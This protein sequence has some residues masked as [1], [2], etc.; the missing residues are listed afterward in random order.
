MNL[1]Q[2][3]EKRN[4][5]MTDMSAIVEG[6]FTAEKRTQFDTM[7]QEI[8]VLDGDI[9]RVKAVEE[10]RA[11]MKN[12]VNQPRPNPSESNDPEERAE[13]RAARQKEAL[14]SYM[15]T[16][17]VESRDLT[18]AGQGVAI[19]VGF[20]ST[21]IEAQK[22]YGEIYDIVTVI[23]TDTGQP[24]KMVLDND[25]GNS[26]T[27]VTVGTNAGEVDPTLS[28]VTL[29]VDNYTTGVIKVDNGFLT[30]AGFDVDQWIR[31]RFLK[32]FFRGA[33]NLIVNGD[34]GNVASLATAANANYVSSTTASVISYPDFP[35]LLAELDPAYYQNACWAMNQPTLSAV[36]GLKDN[37]DRPLFLPGLG[38]A[39]QGFIGTI[40][41]W[42]VKLVTQLPNIADSAFPILFGDFKEGYTFRQQNPGIG[43]LRLNELFAAGYETG[44]VGFAR[45]GGVVTDA[46]THPIVSLKITPAA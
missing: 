42:P 2:L 26:L 1:S 32:R 28:G 30:D 35:A 44:F 22:S 12:P 7:T 14:R 29:Q 10:A 34:G 15:R 45:V 40:L 3:L 27:S 24:I 16:G 11:A 39:S 19:P 18:V 43:I 5:L 38:D 33:S 37:N 21:V 41:G 6:D 4:K 13:V 8:S 20:D 46:G 36:V 9:A 25:T 31:G 17:K 23:K